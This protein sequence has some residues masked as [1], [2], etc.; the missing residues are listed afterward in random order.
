[1]NG[2]T[3]VPNFTK[4]YYAVQNVF[5]GVHREADRLVI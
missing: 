2:I 5:V 1:M 3:F 4:I